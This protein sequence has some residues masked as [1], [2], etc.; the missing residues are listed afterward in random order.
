MY[1]WQIINSVSSP[2]KWRLIELVQNNHTCHWTD[3]SRI[4]PSQKLVYFKVPSGA[5]VQIPYFGGY[6][7]HTLGVTGYEKRRGTKATDKPRKW[8][9]MEW[10]H[11]ATTKECGWEKYPQKILKVSVSKRRVL[12]SGACCCN[13]HYVQTPNKTGFVSAKTI[14]QSQTTNC[15]MGV[16]LTV[17]LHHA[18][19]PWQWHTYDFVT[20]WQTTILTN[21]QSSAIQNTTCTS[22]KHIYRHQHR[23]I[24]CA[25]A[26][27]TSVP[28]SARKNP[29]GLSD[30]W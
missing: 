1:F 8:G 9:C 29:K 30:S 26:Q 4:K 6:F 19:L 25:L 14:C 20:G 27:K 15:T 12:E 16:G 22:A 17:T 3:L 21:K 24:F 7:F 11:P 10:M 13:V 18:N 23:E 5:I 2:G 28:S